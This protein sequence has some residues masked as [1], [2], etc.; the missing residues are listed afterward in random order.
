MA[1]LV[2]DMCAEVYLYM[3]HLLTDMCAEGYL[4]RHSVRVA[5]FQIS[6]TML[7]QLLQ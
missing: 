5:T 1:H 6:K 4:L 2:S 3:A 7:V